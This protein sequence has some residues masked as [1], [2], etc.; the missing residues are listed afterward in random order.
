MAVSARTWGGGAEK[1][2]DLMMWMDIEMAHEGAEGGCWGVREAGCCDSGRRKPT[3][4]PV[5]GRGSWLQEG[6]PHV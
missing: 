4:Y 2:C 1:R 6:I 5:M 3:E